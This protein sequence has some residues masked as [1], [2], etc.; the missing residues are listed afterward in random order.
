MAHLFI[1]REEYE[2]DKSY[3]EDLGQNIKVIVV[4]DAQFTLPQGSCAKLLKKPFYSLPIVNILNAGAAGDEELLKEKRMICPG[5]RVL[6]VDDEPMNLMVAEGIF[7]DYQMSVTTA[8]SGRKAIELCGK[9][10]FDLIFLDHMMPEMD[11]VE[12]LKRLRKN[13]TDTART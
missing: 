4:A 1:G 11:G 9:E 3:F 12:T 2:E 6:V 7:R 13:H 8:E 5:I 10:D